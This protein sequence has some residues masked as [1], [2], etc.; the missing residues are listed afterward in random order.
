M[1]KTEIAV[2]LLVALVFGFGFIPALGA[3]I[4]RFT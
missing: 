2:A 3:A 4:W 1:T